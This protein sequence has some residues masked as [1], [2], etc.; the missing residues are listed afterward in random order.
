[1]SRL[2]M[3]GAEWG[4]NE[5]LTSAGVDAT[6]IGSTAGR[7]HGG[8]RYFV[9]NPANGA[10]DCWHRLNLA[11]IGVTGI[12]GTDYFL[13]CYITIWNTFG[14]GAVLMRVWSGATMLCSIR[15]GSSRQYQFFNDVAGT[16]VGSD[17]PVAMIGL[18]G[19]DRVEFRVNIG[20][21]AVDSIE[22]RVDGVQIGLATGLSLAEAAPDVFNW[23]CVTSG[24]TITNVIMDD[25]AINANTG[26]F[27]TSWPG[28]GNMVLI[29]PISDNARVGYVN[30]AAGTTNLWDAL[31]N[32]PPVGSGTGSATTRIHSPTNN[33]TDTYDANLET[34]T[35]AGLR[36]G[37][38]VTVIMP[39]VEVGGASGTLDSQGIQML[40]NPVI[41][42]S[43]VA[44]VASVWGN[45][46]LGW[47]NR[48]GLAAYNQSVTLGTSPVMRIRRATANASQ[49]GADA[50]GAYV[51]YVPGSGKILKQTG[52]QQAVKA[53]SYA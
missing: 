12:L 11:T 46:P 29:K 34:Y 15:L 37:D 30:G 17:G 16:Q 6:A 44:K 4:G 22:A 52:A 19:G 14:T 43:T 40:S 28:N 25:I 35:A 7:A 8:S 20:T 32:I 3:W 31:D 18:G 1:M 21:G 51:E 10:S 24:G 38:V 2:G 53:A 48:F 23:G 42:E 9:Y 27:Q 33:A 36:S 45:S 47:T 26:I 49:L 5:G 39:W 50:M 41:G 13:R